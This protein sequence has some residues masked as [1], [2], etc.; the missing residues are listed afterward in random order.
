MQRVVERHLS[1]DARARRLP[2]PVTEQ[3][4][5]FHAALSEPNGSLEFSVHDE[6]LDS[7]SGPGDRIWSTGDVSSDLASIATAGTSDPPRPSVTQPR[8]AC[9]WIQPSDAEPA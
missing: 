2:G 9:A 3:P 8:P 4:A 6:P 7:V 5:P 1:A